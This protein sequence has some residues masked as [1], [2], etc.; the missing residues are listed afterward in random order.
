MPF[1]N[2]KQFKILVMVRIAPLEVVVEEFLPG[3]S[4]DLCG[5]R[6]DAVEV[7]DDGIIDLTRDGEIGLFANHITLC[8]LKEYGRW[9]VVENV[10]RSSLSN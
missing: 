9:F 7:K 4:V 3:G 5:L 2:I 6:D 8:P 10:V 1:F